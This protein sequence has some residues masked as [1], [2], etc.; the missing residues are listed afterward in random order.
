M[1]RLPWLVCAILFFAISCGG[2]THVVGTGADGSAG[3]VGS[4]GNAQAS[5]S[6]S[7]LGGAGASGTHE[8]DAAAG[9]ATGGIDG[10]APVGSGGAPPDAGAG[11]PATGGAT[12][13]DAG[14]T[15][16]FATGGA[17]VGGAGGRDGGVG[18]TVQT[19]GAVQSGGSSASGGS[20]SSS[21]SC[22]QSQ[23]TNGASCVGSSAWC[24]YQ[25]CAGSGVG[26]AYCSSD[27]WSVNSKACAEFA[28]RPFGLGSSTTCPAGQ[29]CVANW[30]QD[31]KCV[32]HTCGTSP[33]TLECVPGVN[34]GT[35]GRCSFSTGEGGMRVECCP[36]K[37]SAC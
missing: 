20:S 6:R 23:P 25:D 17:G 34:P 22:P 2:T 5:D 31:P 33:V 1:T 11:I 26:L 9:G 37:G 4:G 3:S 18:G 16:G 35:E 10:A 28:C 21:S 12:L 36:Y 7:L 24:L 30:G 14:A 27:K 32:P 13:L 19:G 8:I 29:I 15:G